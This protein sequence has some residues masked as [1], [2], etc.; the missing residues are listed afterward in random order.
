MTDLYR[1]HLMDDGFHVQRFTIEGWRT[2]AIYHARHMAVRRMHEL[3]K[4]GV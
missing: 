4:Y 1:V 3:Q 2:Y